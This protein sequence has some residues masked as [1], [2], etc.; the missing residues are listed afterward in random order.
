MQPMLLARF[1]HVIDA[2]TPAV[3]AD[4]HE[5][6]RHQGLAPCAWWTIPTTYSRSSQESNMVFDQVVPSIEKFLM[7]SHLTSQYRATRPV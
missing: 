5:A 2:E 4:Y 6:A 1:L 3:T 7:S